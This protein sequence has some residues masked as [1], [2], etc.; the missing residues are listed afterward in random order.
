MKWMLLC[1]AP[2]WTVMLF[3]PFQVH[4]QPYQSM[5]S[6]EDYPTQWSFAWYNISIRSVDTAYVEKDTVVD[7]LTYKKVVSP[8]STQDG[9]AGGLFRED[10][11]NG[12]VWYR[13]IP[14]TAEWL[15]FRFDL[16]E[17]D[18]FDISNT[19]YPRGSYPD[20]LNIVDSV[21]VLHGLRHIYFKAK[22]A[23]LPTEPYTL[24]EG[25]GSNM[26]IFC[27]HGSDPRIGGVGGYVT[28]S[29][30]YLLC[31]YKNGQK[32]PFHNRRYD[33]NCQP[34]GKS[35]NEADEEASS[36]LGLT[37]YPQPARGKV[38]IKNKLGQPVQSIQ[39]YSSH[40]KLFQSFAGNDLEE[41]FTDGWP[42]GLYYIRFFSERGFLGVKPLI[43]Q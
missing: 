12:K 7:G 32:T 2:L 17:G 16:Q 6:H 38:W 4:A 35:I 28:L 29:T 31:T 3:A 1:S 20:S 27:K 13:G 40:G 22:V 9:F 5:F 8:V 18:T 36:L 33:G 34:F 39:V 11:L 23:N 42:S 21:R 10:T 25:I 24:I 26:G 43:V 19:A 15:A 41:F 14:D 30:T 37:L